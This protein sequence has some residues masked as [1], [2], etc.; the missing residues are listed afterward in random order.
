MDLLREREDDDE[1]ADG[2]CWCCCWKGKTGKVVAAG[3]ATD[4]RL[5]LLGFEGNAEV[6]KMTSLHAACLCGRDAGKC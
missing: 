1:A 2:F 6:Y 5:C 4:R 3:V